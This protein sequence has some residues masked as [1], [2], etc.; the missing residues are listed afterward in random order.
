MKQNHFKNGPA[1]AAILACGIGCAV[2]GL[3]T[4]LGHIHVG[5]SR[6]LVWWEP[7]GSLLGKAGAAIAAW[8]LSWGVLQSL[9]GHSEIQRFKLV[10][11][12]AFFGIF[13]GWLGTFPPFFEWVGHLK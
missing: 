2:L 7:T 6:A 4:F 5:W 1:A 9:W 10:C 11:R 8:L 13:L 3:M 12:L